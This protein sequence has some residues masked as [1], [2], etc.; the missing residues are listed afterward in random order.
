MNIQKRAL[1]C[2][3]SIVS[4]ATLQHA[5]AGKA[6]L[7]VYGQEKAESSKVDGVF[8]GTWWVYTHTDGAV[9]PKS[10]TKKAPRKLWLDGRWVK[11]EEVVLRN[12]TLDFGALVEQFSGEDEAWAFTEIYAETAKTITVGAGAD[13]WMEWFLNRKSVFSTME[14]GNQGPTAVDAH[15][16]EFPLKAGTNGVAVKVVSG[17]LGWKLAC[18]EKVEQVQQDNQFQT[19]FPVGDIASEYILNLCDDPVF[20][21]ARPVE[22]DRGTVYEIDLKKGQQKTIQRYALQYFHDGI[23]FYVKG[24]GSD[25]TLKL[26]LRVF[27]DKSKADHEY[28]QPYE[29]LYSRPIKLSSKDWKKV[30]LTYAEDFTPHAIAQRMVGNDIRWFKLVCDGK[31]DGSFQIDDI[32]YVNTTMEP[33]FEIRHVLKESHVF[34]RDEPVSPSLLVYSLEATAVE[35]KFHL[36]RSDNRVNRI[37]TQTVDVPAGE[38]AVKLELP[39]MSTGYYSLTVKATPETGKSFKAGGYFSVVPQRNIEAWMGD[40][41]GGAYLYDR[42]ELDDLFRGGYKVLRQ[43]GQVDNVSFGREEEWPMVDR[44]LKPRL[45]MGFEV[46]WAQMGTDKKNMDLPRFEKMRKN[47]K[48]DVKNILDYSYKF[49]VKNPQQMEDALAIAAGKYGDRIKYWEFGNELDRAVYPGV[50]HGKF[51]WWGTGTDYAEDLKTFYTGIKRGNPDALV[52]SSGVTCFIH[53]PARGEFITEML[54]ATQGEYFDVFGLHGYGGMEN[55]DVV[56]NDLHARGIHKPFANTERGFRG[57]NRSSMTLAIKEV[58]FNKEREALFFVTFIN[59]CKKYENEGKATPQTAWDAHHTRFYEGS[60]TKMWALYSTAAFMLDGAKNATTIKNKPYGG[61]SFQSAEGFGMLLFKEGAPVEQTFSCEGTVRI[62]DLQGNESFVDQKMFTLTIEDLPFYV[63]SSE[64]LSTQETLANEM[65]FKVHE[66][67]VGVSIDAGKSDLEM[68]GA[69]EGW[70]FAPAAPSASSSALFFEATEMDSV[71]EGLFSLATAGGKPAAFMKQTVLLDAS[72]TAPVSVDGKLGEWDR[73]NQIMLSHAGQLALG[74]PAWE[75]QIDPNSY[76]GKTKGTDN[77]AASVSFTSGTDHLY[78]GIEV[79]DDEVNIT[80]SG[81]AVAEQGDYLSIDFFNAQ[82]DLESIGIT[83]SANGDCIVADKG[84]HAKWVGTPTG[85]ACEIE[86]P[87]SRLAVHNARMLNLNVNVFDSD[88]HLGQVVR[89]Y[90]K[91][92]MGDAESLG[93]ERLPLLILSGEAAE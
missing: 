21:D 39:G 84:I 48:V 74:R 33:K 85:Y 34:Y 10:I 24:D 88:S 14:H 81:R 29:T 56:L 37:V 52:I 82:G 75:G 54:D 72:L 49:P 36:N 58:F 20:G 70:V 25:S 50:K 80:T 60:P 11:G 26:A 2:A 64:P 77:L 19:F 68:G 27:L 42:Y 5:N 61:Y 69:P 30:T 92:G 62:V 9:N 89:P 12:D 47:L 31:S 66:G 23:S 93:E 53:L 18:A 16:F 71:Y 13:W 76:Y 35:F 65:E 41:E 6:T 51:C 87:R 45:D 4:I 91:M 43:A 3:V 32:R 73:S 83:P 1:A 22:S 44:F 63:I 55:L 79:F 28:A 40:H 78:L 17:L 57:V 67:A 8:S 15:F 86:I 90:I 59:R 7:P 46:V 38:S